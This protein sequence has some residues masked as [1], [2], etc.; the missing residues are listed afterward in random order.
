MAQSHY[1]L[2]FP[3]VGAVARTNAFYGQGTGPI[4]FDDL[5]C[6][7]SEQRLI[8]CPFTPIHN[9]RHSEDAGVD[10]A[11]R[12]N[13]QRAFSGQQCLHKITS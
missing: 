12:S 3:C 5:G 1:Q 4:N 11:P 13:A 10:C 8:D 2:T 9:C 6:T 7:G